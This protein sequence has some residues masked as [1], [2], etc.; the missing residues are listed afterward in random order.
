MWMQSYLQRAEMTQKQLTHYQEVHP[1]TGEDHKI[2]NPG[3]LCPAC[4]QLHN[5]ATSYLCGSSQ[6]LASIQSFTPQLLR[7]DP[8]TSSNNSPRM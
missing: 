1:S 3:A 2:Y 7:K 6:N 5:P 8:P 4:R